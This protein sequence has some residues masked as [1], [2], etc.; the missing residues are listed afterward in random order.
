M[1]HLNPVN[2]ASARG[3]RLFADDWEVERHRLDVSTLGFR[4]YIF[5]SRV[6]RVSRFIESNKAIERLLAQVKE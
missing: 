6:V 5:T 3:I 1:I 2:I 4:Q